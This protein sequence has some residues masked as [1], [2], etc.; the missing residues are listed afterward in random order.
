MELTLTL[1]T[2][3][4]FECASGGLAGMELAEV[5]GRLRAA[6]AAVMRQAADG[7]E[8]ARLA[9]SMASFHED[10]VRAFLR[11]VAGSLARLGYACREDGSAGSVSDIFYACAA[12][13]VEA[14]AFTEAGIGLAALLAEPDLRSKGL[15]GLAVCAARLK[16]FDEALAFALESQ[17]LEGNSHPRAFFVAGLSECERGHRREAQTYLVRASRLARREARFDDLRMAQRLL[18]LMQIGISEQTRL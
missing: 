12:E 4:E 1:P 8:I 9:Q 6:L 15:L 10:H 7:S 5:E 18:L 11:R 2:D 3:R 13:A 17:P 16:R 14:G